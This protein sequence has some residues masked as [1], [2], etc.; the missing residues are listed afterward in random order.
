MSTE[1]EIK[2]IENLSEEFLLKNKCKKIYVVCPANRNAGGVDALHQMVYYLNEMHLNAL[3]VYV[4]NEVDF[5]LAKFVNSSKIY[6][7]KA[8]E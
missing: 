1:G 4:S 3:V 2:S 7:Q 8:P 5:L 6:L